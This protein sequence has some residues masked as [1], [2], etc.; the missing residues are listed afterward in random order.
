[1]V[2]SR[3]P[4]ERRVKRGVCGVVTS[5]GRDQKAQ[6]GRMSNTLFYCYWRCW[7]GC[8]PLPVTA[9]DSGCIGAHGEITTPVSGPQ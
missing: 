2:N 9:C 6:Q 5:A 7:R 1:M 8:L 3:V 4:D